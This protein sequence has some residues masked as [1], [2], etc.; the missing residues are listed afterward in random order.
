MP[1][2]YAPLNIAKA[3]FALQL[4][5]QTCYFKQNKMLTITRGRVHK[6]FFMLN[7]AEHEIY[8]AH[9]Y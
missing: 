6:T 1:K 5:N 9:K 7:S 8:P 3:V 2:S 4:E